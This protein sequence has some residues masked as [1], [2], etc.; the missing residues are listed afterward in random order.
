MMEKETGR[1]TMGSKFAKVSVL[2]TYIGFF[3]LERVTTPQFRAWRR[4]GLPLL[5]ARMKHAKA[6]KPEDQAISLDSS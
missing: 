2:C 6:I 3:S 1:K 4:E 5:T